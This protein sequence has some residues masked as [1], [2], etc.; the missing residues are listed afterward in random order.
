MP[1]LSVQIGGS[2]GPNNRKNTVNESYILFVSKI[3]ILR[4]MTSNFPKIPAYTHRVASS[5]LLR[6]FG[7]YVF[8][9]GEANWQ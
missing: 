5:D 8:Y 1:R 3:G 7:G 9:V 2:R 6:R 4:G